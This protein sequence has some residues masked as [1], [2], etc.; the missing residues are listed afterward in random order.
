[1]Q[2]RDEPQSHRPQWHWPVLAAW[3]ASLIGLLRL[4][5]GVIHLRR[6]RRRSTHLTDDELQQLTDELRTHYHINRRVELRESQKLSVAATVGW[7]RPLVLLPPSWRQWTADERRAVLA[8]ELAHVRQ[9]HFPAWLLAQITVVA[10]FYHPLVHWLASRLRFEQE[11]AADALAAAAFPDR[12]QYTAAIAGLALGKSPSPRL[13]TPLGLFM[14]RPLIMRRIAMLRQTNEPSRKSSR[15]TRLVM[16][17][18]IMSIGVGVAGLRPLTDT[19]AAQPAAVQPNAPRQ[20][21]AQ[22]AAAQG[23]AALIRQDVPPTDANQTTRVVYLFQV[24][25]EAADSSGGGADKV[26]DSAWNSFRFTQIALIKSNWLMQVV[27][28]NPKVAALPLVKAQ[29]HPTAWLLQQVKVDFPSASEILQIWMTCTPD[30]AD[31][32]RQIVDAVA[33]AYVDEVIYKNRQQRLV[34]IG[35]LRK[36][37]DRLNVE[38]RHDTANYLDLAKELGSA[39]ADAESQVTQQLVLRRLDRIEAELM[40]LEGEQLEAHIAQDKT[41]AEFH[42]ARIEQLKKQQ[43]ELENSIRKRNTKSVDLTLIER[44]LQLSQQLANDITL[45][46]QAMEIDM[47]SPPR[48]RQL[49]E[50][51]IISDAGRSQPGTGR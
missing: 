37:L 16:L 4:L 30:E 2:L 3:A 32:A 6:C 10:H 27:L 11:L 35:V 18:V 31:Q 33:K 13:I 25:R 24:S 44:K 40:R 1:M 39:A 20:G 49:Y 47:E 26:S 5:F 43:Q 9:R 42:T 28:R 50:S 45:K 21:A 41:K 51:A 22:P 12:R 17:L 36:S 34:E 23:E 46:L 14:S 19:Q 29:P 38:I 8:H 48:I 7:L 15:R